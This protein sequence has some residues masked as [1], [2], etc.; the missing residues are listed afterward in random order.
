MLREIVENS[1][2]FLDITKKK[3]N[4]F[5]SQ[6]QMLSKK[7]INQIHEFFFREALIKNEEKIPSPFLSRPSVIHFNGKCS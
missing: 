1:D 4:T 5:Y 6:A 7:K 3:K 2:G